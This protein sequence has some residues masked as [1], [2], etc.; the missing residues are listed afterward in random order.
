MAT[1]SRKHEL[2]K[3]RHSRV[4]KGLEGTAQRPRLCVF[5]SNRNIYCQVVDDLAGH[6]LTSA[7]TLSAELH[8]ELKQGGNREAAARVGE[9]LAQKCIEKGIGEV[10]FDRGG[11]KFHGRVKALAEA[12]RKKF[13]EAGAR[14]F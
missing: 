14:G 10:V 5:R 1:K 8:D 6:T 2:R 4:R 7:S 11:Y 3:R 9:I 12:T 13:E